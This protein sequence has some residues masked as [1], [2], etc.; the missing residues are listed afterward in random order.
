MF[1]A[2]WMRMLTTIYFC[3]E[4]WFDVTC[5]YL[6][7]FVSFSYTLWPFFV[8]WFLVYLHI[9]KGRLF[10]LFF[11]HAQSGIW[12]QPV[13]VYQEF[14]KFVR[15]QIKK[16]SLFNAVDSKCS[17][18]I[19]ATIG[20]MGY[21][22]AAPFAFSQTLALAIEFRDDVVTNPN[23]NR[24]YLP[25]AGNQDRLAEQKTTRVFPMMIDLLAA[26]WA[27]VAKLCIS[28]EQGK[29]LPPCLRCV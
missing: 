7:A 26:Y 16:T 5:R 15:C 8:E 18:K 3:D 17:M 14:M 22:I 6:L 28:T 19:L 4:C 11:L 21:P 24:A 23:S 12:R 9:K 13:Y 25:K 20:E 29:L 1:M 10:I 2:L 27:S